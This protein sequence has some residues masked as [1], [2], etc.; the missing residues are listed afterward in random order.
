[1]RLAESAP[2]TMFANEHEASKPAKWSIGDP[3]PEVLPDEV[4]AAV[5]EKRFVT[6]PSNFVN[7]KDPVKNKLKI[8]HDLSKPAKRIKRGS[9]IIQVL[10]DDGGI[11]P[12]KVS[13]RSMDIRKTWLI[14][15]CGPQ[16]KE[17]VPRRKTV[18]GFVRR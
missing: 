3:L 2:E 11:L 4:L 6:P 10:E 17:P 12:P 8:F 15:R 18:G 16:G 14:G 9:V 7:P 1:M 13:K 5:P